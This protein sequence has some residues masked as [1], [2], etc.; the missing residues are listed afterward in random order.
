M[1]FAP[2]AVMVA[3]WQGRLPLVSAVI[4]TVG[5]VAS[6]V[7]LVLPP[8]NVWLVPDRLHISLM[9]EAL[10]MPV[11]FSALLPLKFTEDDT[12]PVKYSTLV[13]APPAYANVPTL[14]EMVRL[15]LKEL[16][17]LSTISSKTS[18][19]VIGSPG[20][21]VPPAI[22]AMPRSTG[23]FSSCTMT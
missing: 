4:V 5:F 18:A 1:V 7:T 23:S 15:L 14:V 10:L 2:V 13:S 9:P 6:T 8:G 12:V 16:F 3:L 19:T 17:V 11:T 20:R 21:Y 22:G